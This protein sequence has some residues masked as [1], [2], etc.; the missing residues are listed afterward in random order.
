MRTAEVSNVSSPHLSVPVTRSS[1]G[2][3]AGR[4]L[5]ALPLLFLAFDTI[6]KVLRMPVALEAT[7]EL[8]FTE[9][10]VFAIG[11]VEAVCLVLYLVPRT[12]I[13]GAV[14]WTAYFGGAIA[15]HVRADSPLFTHTLFPIYM[16]AF[17]WVGLALRDGRLRRIVRAAFNVNE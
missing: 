2:V 12:A 8:G 1:R 5:C 15:T 13:L 7:R 6:I 14:L 16:A 17:L 3:W 10:A 11:V 9:S 4:A